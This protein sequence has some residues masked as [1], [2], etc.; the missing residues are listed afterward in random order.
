VNAVVNSVVFSAAYTL[1]PAVMFGMAAY[2]CILGLRKYGYQYNKKLWIPFFLGY[3][4]ISAVVVGLLAGNE[5]AGT[6]VIRLATFILIG[7]LLAYVIGFRL[8]FGKKKQDKV[9]EQ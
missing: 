9:N 1:I 4:L 2:I 5:F 3:W 7:S 8:I 6:M